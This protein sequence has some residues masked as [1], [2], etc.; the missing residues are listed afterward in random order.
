GDSTVAF[1]AVSCASRTFCE[2][3]GG[4]NGG[5]P[6]PTVAERWN[7]TS[8]HL[9]AVPTSDAVPDSMSCASA[10][11]CEALTPTGGYRWNGSSWT[12]QATP[13]LG[14]GLTGVSCVSATFC[15]AVAENFNSAPGTLAAKWN[16]SA[17]TVQSISTPPAAASMMMAAVTCSSASAC[18]AVGSFGLGTTNAAPRAV[19]ESWNGHSWALQDAVTPPGATANSLRSVS[20]VSLTFCEAVGSFTD[21]T[22]T[23]G[24]SMAEMWNGKSWKVQTMPGAS[25]SV[26]CVSATF[27]EAVGPASAANWNGTTWTL[28][29]RPGADVE[30][31]AVSCATVTFCMAVDGFAQT[32]IWNGTAWSAGPTVTGFTSQ[33]SPVESVSCV[34]A[35]F[36]EAVGGGSGGDNAAV[37]NGTSWTAQPTPGPASSF[38]SAV[39]CPAVNSCEAVGSYADS[40]FHE[41]AFAEV[42]N[43]TTWAAQTIPNPSISRGTSLSAIS[44]T[45]ADS[46][47]AVGSYQYSLIFLGHTL[48]EVWNGTTWSLRSTPSDPNA[49]LSGVSCGASGACTAVGQRLDEGLIPTTLIEVGD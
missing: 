20:C 47:T 43:G 22:G 6:G 13:S 15:E 46:C 44:C 36:C 3:W 27:C 35:S 24:A 14:G 8:W 45:S 34:S 1:T 9:Q 33:G 25:F 4:G 23:T 38:L 49:G 18:E 16:G 28:Q 12:A 17:W 7:G 29:Q 26:S 41:A 10:L 40:S 30:P 2:A 31:V 11:F 37:W 48:A 5:S 42:W 19:A 21:G 39:S 32:A